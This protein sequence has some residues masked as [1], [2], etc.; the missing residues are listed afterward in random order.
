MPRYDFVHH[1]RLEES[2]PVTPHQ[3]IIFEGIMIFFDRRIRELI[4]LKIFI[5]TPDDIRFIRRL[6]RD[7]L[8]RGRTV[9]SVIQQYLGKV[10]PGHLSFIEPT[11]RLPTSLSLR[12]ASTRWPSRCWSPF[13]DPKPIHGISRIGALHDFIVRGYH[14]RQEAP[15][16]VL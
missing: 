12:E 9:D 7:I 15:P 4:D 5:D 14:P 8:E 6:Q 11:K 3:L 13:S 10:R 1:C 16:A 2:T